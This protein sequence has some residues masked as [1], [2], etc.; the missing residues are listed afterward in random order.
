MDKFK[1][2]A[3]ITLLMAVIIISCKTRFETTKAS[4]TAMRSAD[5]FERGKELTFSICAGC[6]YNHSTNKFT[7]NKIEDIPGIAGTVFSANLTHSKT[8]GATSRY[9][10]AEIR[11]L[12][13]TG[14]AR[15]GRFLSYMLR[16]N[17][18]EDDI[19]AIIV[20]LRSDD[21]AVAADNTIAGV[22]HF[23]MLGKVYMN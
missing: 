16:P 15:D 11:H 20:Y 22:T 19:N 13:K 3:G 14:V 4:F 7:G 2:I 18:A 10:D 23:T 9:S 5:A 6:H 12:L 8:H 1:W 21:R 17:M